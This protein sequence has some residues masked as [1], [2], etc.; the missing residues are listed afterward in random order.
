M[1]FALFRWFPKSGLTRLAGWLADR[2]RPQWMLRAF[3]P[4][5]AR[6]FGI[7]MAQFVVPPEGW[8][9][10]NQFFTREVKPGARPIAAGA[11]TLISPVD[12]RVIEAGPIRAGKLLQAKGIEYGL[13]DLLGGDPTWRSYDGGAFATIYLHPRDYHRI[14]TPCAGEVVRFRYVPGDLWTV[15]PAGVRGVPGL[16]ARNERWISFLRTS[17]GEAAVV[18]VGATSVGRIRV[19]YHPGVSHLWH[20]Q[21]LAETLSK[22]HAL[23]AGAELG[24]FELGS[25]VILLTRP[26]E[27]ALNPLQ[28]GDTVR[29]GAAIGRVTKR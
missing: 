22:P 10:F 4:F 20:A 16:F 3:I 17:W 19:V 23:A 12:G 9:T 14:H 21:P 29:M 1:Y 7:D 11:D 15:S 24:R 8:P 28:S 2:R 6:V 27:A 13:E 5:Y 18:K 25:T 26:G